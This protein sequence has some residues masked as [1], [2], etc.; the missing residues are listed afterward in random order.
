[1]DLFMN[2]ERNKRKVMELAN[3]IKAH[4]FRVFVLLDDD[5]GYYYGFFTNGDNVAYF[6]VDW[7][8]YCIAK[9]TIPSMSVRRTSRLSE[10][11]KNMCDRAVSSSIPN[12]RGKFKPR[13]YK[14]DDMMRR[15]GNDKRFSEL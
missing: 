5:Y 15:Y 11:T 9:C 7:D 4:G 3:A 8:D 6:D 13:L 14:F 12:I 10:I 1:M 2:W